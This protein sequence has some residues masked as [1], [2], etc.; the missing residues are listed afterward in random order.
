MRLQRQHP[1]APDD[2]DISVNVVLVS[3]GVIVATVRVVA[4]LSRFST[5]LVF[6]PS[7]RTGRDIR[8]SQLSNSKSLSSHLTRF[9]MFLDY[10]ASL[11]N[12]VVDT[13]EPFACVVVVLA[14]GAGK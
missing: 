3:L 12:A 7:G 4:A 5:S 14:S 8:F 10:P 13:H 6:W 11:K 1:N 2:Q 9:V